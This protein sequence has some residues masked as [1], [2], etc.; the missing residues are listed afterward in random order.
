ML[1]P[2][3]PKPAELCS[4]DVVH[5]GI[6]VGF[7]GKRP[8]GLG[9]KHT[10]LRK[11]VPVEHRGMGLGVSRLGSQYQCWF[12]LWGRGRKW[13]QPGPLSP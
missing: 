13:G 3:G 5:A 12:M 2:L 8:T 10:C 9:L 1:L 7:L 11:A 4:K 6:S